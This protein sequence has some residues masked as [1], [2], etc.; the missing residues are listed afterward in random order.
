MAAMIMLEHPTHLG[1]ETG[2]EQRI[3]QQI[4]IRQPR[5][6][7][8]SRLGVLHG[9]LESPRHAATYPDALRHRRGY[10]RVLP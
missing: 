1:L 2:S 7:Y 8:P 6:D 10:L 3:D 9:S 4:V 5:P